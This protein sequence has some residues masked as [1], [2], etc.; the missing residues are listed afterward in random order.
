MPLLKYFLTVGTILTAGL[1]ALSAYLEPTSRESA[2]RVAVAPTTA[3]LLSFA[4]KPPDPVKLSK[5]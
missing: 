3:S 4:P 2:A 1:L 5:R